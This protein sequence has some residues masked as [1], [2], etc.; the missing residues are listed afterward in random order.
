MLRI[1]LSIFLLFSVFAHGQNEKQV[2]FR[3]LT[4]DDGLSQNSMVSVAQD[5]TGYLWFATQDGLN[6]YDGTQFVT[7]PKFFEDITR[8]TYSKLGK[9]YVTPS[10]RLFI[11]TIEGK[12]E[13]FDADVNTFKSVP[14]SDT[15]SVFYEGPSG[16]VWIG[17]YG[18]GLYRASVNSSDTLQVL[19][20]GDRIR[21]V[22]HITS[23][24]DSLAIAA[25]GGLFLMDPVTGNYESLSTNPAINFSSATSGD[26]GTLWAGTYGN[27]LWLWS[28]DVGLRQFTGFGGKVEISG[29]LNIQSILWTTKGELWLGTYGNG[30][31]RVDFATET[32]SN[33]VSDVYDPQSIN[34]NDV[35]CLFEDH[36]GVVW[37]GTDGGGLNYYDENLSKFNQM[38]NAQVPLFA[39]VDVPR[40]IT[41]DNKGRLWIGTS[42]KGLTQYSPDIGKFGMFTTSTPKDSPLPS[43]RVMSLLGRGDQMWVGFQDGGLAVIDQGVRIFDDSSNP[44][45]PAQTVWCILKGENESAWLGTRSNGLIEFDLAKGVI[46]QFT[47]ENSNIPS[48]N[49]RVITHGS[50]NDIWIGSEDQGLSRFLPETGQFIPYSHHGFAGIK[51]LLYEAPI[52]WIGTNGKGLYRLDTETEKWWSFTSE[53]GLPN[54]VIYGVLP[55]AAGN[56]WL[57]S[58]K[59]LTEFA[60]SDDGNPPL[61]TNY[62]TGD[63]LQSM[64]FNTGAS[65]KADDGTLYFGGLNGVNW[66]HPS[67]LSSN[68]IPPK[69]AITKLEV[70]SDEWPLVQNEIFKAKEN[71][72]SFTF[73]GLHFSQPRNNLYKYRLVN[74]EDE[75]SKPSTIN[76]VHYPRLPHGDYIFE[77]ASSNYE[78]VWDSSPASFSFSIRPPWYMSTLA[79]IGYILLLALTFYGVYSYLKWR[80]QMKMRLQMEYEESE[81]LRQLD[82][83]K[84]KLYTNISH[85]F[86]TPLTLISGP[87]Q[88]L[89]ESSYLNNK[90]QNS[91]KIIEG[92]SRR[93][94]ELVNQLLDLSKLETGTVE[95][96]IVHQDP[97]PKLLQLTE[98]FGVMAREK[99]ITIES[100][101]KDIGTIW[102]D[103]DVVE[104]IASNLLSNAVKYAPENSTVHFQV[105]RKDENIILKTTNENSSLTE[106]QL[107]KLFVRFYQA[108]K[109]SQGVGVGLALIKE[110]TSLCNGSIQAIKEKPDTVSFIAQLPC[111]QEAYPPEFVTTVPAMTEVEQT[112]TT[113]IFETE[114][115]E[116]PHVLVVE[117]NKE[118]RNYITSLFD[119][120]YVTTEAENGHTGIQ[121]AI[122]AVP[123]LI[124]SDIMMPEKDGIELC[125]TLKEDK[126]TSHIPIILLTAKSGEEN[127]LIGLKNKADDYIT[128]PFNAKVLKQKAANMIE[129]RRQL[130]ERYGQNVYLKPRDIAI[131]SVDEIFL[132]DVEAVL[133][134]KL[135]D[136]D[137]TAQKFAQ[138]LHMSRMQLHRKLKALTD[139]ST[140]EFIRSQRL[141]S[142]ENIMKGSGHTVNEVA[143]AVGFNT[144]SYFI[145]CFKEAYGVTPS[146]YMKQ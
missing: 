68:S 115:D 17:T 129:T 21:D 102:Y 97:R 5:T 143:Y 134:D 99:E 8:G 76:Y 71:T 130:R 7:F 26:S 114:K 90:D 131:T 32:I 107:E 9:V 91:V 75:W 141:K 133:D 128:K 74:Y 70:F 77:V 47:T 4:V 65:Y 73:A 14:F 108:D 69:T 121:K 31:Y 55:D 18:K 104:K 34:Y 145:K 98:N 83:L 136:P 58:N 85:E 105:F 29:N 11:I 127:E 87:V 6:R 62:D 56:L 120:G 93:M 66:F 24:N 101:V 132:E 89:L 80:W 10:G 35:L 126:R 36:A 138:A 118:I 40:A 123:D 3:H 96:Q 82:D 79:Y 16:D 57:S 144:P 22:Y 125:N 146:E 111:G 45:L 81:R 61:I 12:L 110:L 112:E 92:S 137:F 19:K 124:I 63:G 140:T 53:D 64:E 46:R 41:V 42:G 50:E 37:L 88:Q 1:L 142:A 86:R 38:T 33:F 135:T 27:G 44:K 48:N 116:I 122:E 113:S 103:P 94:L 54:D 72:L 20:N 117:D 49:I 39:K 59:G 106:K 100:Q 30:A 51:S 13:E 2:S 67:Q 119:E 139:L 109:N 15:P 28:R 84:S 23:H 95:L 52:L 60:W 25:S 43:D 78:E